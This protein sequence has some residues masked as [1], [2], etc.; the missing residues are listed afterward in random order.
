MPRLPFVLLSSLLFTALPAW[1]ADGG[2]KPRPL[3]LS[4]PRDIV[5]APASAPAGD[6][7]VERNLK[8]PTTEP[9]PGRSLPYGAGYEHR[10]RQF[11]HGSGAAS[12]AAGGGA[13]PG[14][15]GGRRG[16]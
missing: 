7:T 15:A 5:D 14:G 11:E 9:A 16:R 4:L 6:E 8:A 2:S 12:G 10:V 13:A 1:A 3:N